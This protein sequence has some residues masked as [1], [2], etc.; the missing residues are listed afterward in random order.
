MKYNRWVGRC[1]ALCSGLVMWGYLR[2]IVL[3]WYNGN[4]MMAKFLLISL[5]GA[6]GIKNFGLGILGAIAVIYLVI[7]SVL[8]LVTQLAYQIAVRCRHCRRSPGFIWASVKFCPLCGY[9]TDRP[10]A[11]E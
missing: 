5:A 11:A 7:G 9:P 10:A 2:P 6:L 8:M 3:N 4:P 1:V